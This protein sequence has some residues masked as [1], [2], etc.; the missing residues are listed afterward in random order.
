MSSPCIAA[1]TT[2]TAVSSSKVSPKEI[3]YEWLKEIRANVSP[4]PS[5]KCQS[6]SVEDF[7]VLCANVVMSSSSIAVRRAT[8]SCA[9][10]KVSAPSIAARRVTPGLYDWLKVPNE[11]VEAI[12]TVY[13]LQL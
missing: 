13:L 9:H 11:Q 6:L 4:V 2:N 1:K 8:P 10:D 3:A 12:T 7:P 5:Q